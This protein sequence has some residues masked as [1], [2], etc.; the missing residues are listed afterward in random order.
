MQTCHLRTFYIEIERQQCKEELRCYLA[1]SPNGLS[2]NQNLTEK[3]N[4]FEKLRFYRVVK[5][6]Q[7]REVFKQKREDK[8]LLSP[9]KK[10]FK[11]KGRKRFF[12]KFSP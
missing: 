8:R 4:E 6:T 1:E 12:A 3:G 10:Y 5:N 2:E 11:K 9:H 7:K